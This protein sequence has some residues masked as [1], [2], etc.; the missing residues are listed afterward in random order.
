MIYSNQKFT[1]DLILHVVKLKE[2]VGMGP[3]WISKTIQ[4]IFAPHRA[5][6][7]REN[8]PVRYTV[9]ATSS[10]FVAYVV[11]YNINNKSYNCSMYECKLWPSL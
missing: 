9:L 10:R 2:I 1:E 11:A 5:C 7:Y 6:S 3:S 4:E 8:I